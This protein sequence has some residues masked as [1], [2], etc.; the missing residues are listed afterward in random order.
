V[1]SLYKPIIDSEGNLTE[2]GELIADDK[3]LDLADWLDY[4]TFLLTCP[5]RLI[6]IAGKIQQGEALANADMIYLCRWRQR[7]Q[8]FLF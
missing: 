4:K 2:L 1:E 8:K 5:D 7:E 3:A 6:T